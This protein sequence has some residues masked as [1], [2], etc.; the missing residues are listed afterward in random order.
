MLK[1]A[2][3]KSGSTAPTHSQAG[4][5]RRWVVSITLR[6]LYPWKEPVT[7]MKGGR[8]VSGPLWMARNSRPHRV[9]SPGP[10]NPWRDVILSKLF[11]P[12]TR[13]GG[14]IVPA[15]RH[16]ALKEG[17]FSASSSGLFSSEKDPLLI[18]EEAGLVSGLLFWQG[19]S[20]VFTAYF[21]GFLEWCFIRH[22]LT[23]KNK[24]ENRK[25]NLYKSTVC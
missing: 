9:S 4:T 15:I 3:R 10:A 17:V 16:L 11:R 5:R 24:R 13:T 19:K 6:P 14:G 20:R 21:S 23:T 12:P 7:I 2:Q 18:V 1:Q 25:I 8:W 22:L